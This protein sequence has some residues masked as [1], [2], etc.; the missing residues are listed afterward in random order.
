MTIVF[1]C[2]SLEPGKDGVGDYTRRLSAY[3]A[4]KNVNVGI[5]A[6]K[7]KFIN[8]VKEEKQTS[9]NQTITCF[10]I[11]SGLV[12][13][14]ASKIAK[15][16]IDGIRP[17][18][19]SLQFVPYSFQKRGLPFGLL[20]QIKYLGE[21]TQWHI[22]FHELWIGMNMLSPRKEILIGYIQRKIISNLL[23]K[24]KPKFITTQVQLYKFYLEDL[25][26]NVSL[27]PLFSNIPISDLNTSKTKELQINDLKKYGL[28]IVLFGSIHPNAKLK[29]LLE[30]INSFCEKYGITNRIITFVGRSG[31]EKE[32]WKISFQKYDFEIFDLGEKKPNQISE[33]LNM[34]NLGITTTPVLLV[35]KSGTVISMRNH[36]LPILSV[37]KDWIPSRAEVLELPSDVIEFNGSNFESILNFKSKKCD[38]TI[39]D[40]ADNFLSILSNS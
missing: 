14:K 12:T 11:P 21:D 20:K 10:R 8:A 40:V 32:N 17:T 30:N 23:H 2:G 27:L 15:T 34:A 29:D 7:D 19:L 9:D 36:G 35:E 6:L 39:L 37:G 5:L 22:M 33:A 18:L 31:H 3:C 28:R 13:K 4:K 24:I 1:I 16:W 38:T 25:G 26:F